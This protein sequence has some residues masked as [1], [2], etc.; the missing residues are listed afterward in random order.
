MRQENFALCFVTVWLN[1]Q[2]PSKIFK[3]FAFYLFALKHVYVL[4]NIDGNDS[5][6]KYLVQNFKNEILIS[7]LRIFILGELGCFFD[8]IDSEF[9]K[10]VNPNILYNKYYIKYKIE[11]S[12]TSDYVNLYEN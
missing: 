5:I 6:I 9:L 2:V 12:D 10:T 11:Y 1:L 3:L 8:E 7:P 4:K